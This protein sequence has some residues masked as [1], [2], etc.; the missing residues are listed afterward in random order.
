MAVQDYY[1]ALQNLSNSDKIFGYYSGSAIFDYKFDYLTQSAAPGV[2]DIRLNTGKLYTS[3]NANEVLATQV[4]ID[5]DDISNRESVIGYLTKL[6]DLSDKG[7]IKLEVSGSSSFN[8]LYDIDSIDTGSSTLSYMVVNVSNGSGNVESGD[9]NN[10]ISQSYAFTTSSRTTKKPIIVTFTGSE[11]RGYHEVD[12]TGNSTKYIVAT[13][14]SINDPTTSGS[15]P[16]PFNIDWG[17][18][19]DTFTDPN[20]YPSNFGY[21]WLWNDGYKVKHIK[22]NSRSA[23]GDIL[24]DFIKASEWVRFIMSNP[25]NSTGSLIHPASG[26]YA[27]DYQLLNVTKYSTQGYSHLF[28]DQDNI[29]TSFAVDV[30]SEENITDTFT[31]TGDYIVYASSSGTTVEPTRSISVDSSIPQ[32]YF[33]SSSTNYPTEQFF[34]GWAGANYYVNGSLTS[35]NG[36]LDDP[37]Q[38]FNSGSTERDKDGAANYIPSTLPF[39]IDATASYIEVPSSSFVEYASQTNLTQIGPKFETSTGDEIIYYYKEDTNQIIIRGSQYLNTPK[40][41]TPSFDPLYDV[42]LVGPNDSPTT[43]TTL[44]GFDIEVK[45]SQSLWLTRGLANIGTQDGNLWKYNRYLHRPFK[46]YILT[47]TG[48]TELGYGSSEYGIDE[49]G[50]GSVPVGPPPN[51]FESVFIAYSSSKASDRPEDGIYTFDQNL[52]EPLYIT[53]SVNLD[54][55][56]IDIIRSSSYGTASYG[57]NEFEYGGTGSGDDVLTWQTANL[58]LY[59]NNTVIATETTPINSSNIL[60]GLTSTLTTT[61]QPYQVSIGDTLKLSLEVENESSGFNSSLIVSSYTMSFNNLVYPADGLTPVTFNNYLELNDDCDPLINNI[62]GDRPNQRLQD[63]D[64]SV[65]ILNPINFDQIIKDEAVRATVPESNYTQIGF[66]HQRYGGSSTSRRQINE[67]NELDDI[68]STNRFYYPGDVSNINLVNKGKGP[69]LGKVPNIELKN[70][71]IAYFNKLIDPYPT[72]NGKTAYYVKYLIDETGTIFDPT[73][74]DINF[75]IFEKTFQLYDYDLKPTRTKVSLQD[76]E[77][78]KELS[79]LNDG[80]ASTFKLGEYPTP[81]L[82]T[83]TSSLGHTN[84]IILSG[85]PFFGTLGVGSDWTNYGINVNSL[86][87]Q[88]PLNSSLGGDVR[89]YSLDISTTDLYF[90]SGDVI[91]FENNE[92]IPTSS[93]SLGL[94]IDFPLDPLGNPANTSGGNLSDDFTINGSFEFTTTTC[95][96]KY[97][98]RDE[99]WTRYT[100]KQYFNDYISGITNYRQPF[101]LTL[102]PYR[103]GSK[104]NLNFEISSVEL[105]II[106]SPGASNEINYNPIEIERSPNGYNTQ[107]SLTNNEFKITPDSQYLEKRIIQDLLGLNWTDPQIRKEQAHL[108]GGGYTTVQGQTTGRIAGVNNI[109]VIYKWKINFKFKNIKQEDDFY[110]KVDGAWTFSGDSNVRYGKTDDFFHMHGTSTNFLD[111]NQ[112]GDISWRGTFTPD[113]AILNPAVSSYNTKPILKYIVTSPLSSNNQNA[114]GAPGPYWR[115]ITGTNDMLFMSSSILNQ[116]YGIFDEN[117]NNTNGNYYVQAKLDYIPGSSTDFPSTIEPSFTEFD[118][119]VDP[120]SL[121]IGDEIRFE[122]NENLVYTITSVDGRQAI[123]PPTNPESTNPENDGLRIIVSPPFED[124][125]G[126]LNEPSNFDFFVVRRYKE[127]KNFI[128]LDQQ[129]PYGFPVSASSS[130]GILLPEHRI[131]KYDRNPDEVLKD[132]IEKRI[133]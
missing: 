121:K 95:P 50:S 58:K 70:G 62:V 98:A 131:E 132:L 25:I 3:S 39:F 13:S 36:T 21:A 1:F 44:E 118:P 117:G 37:L 90:I 27:E 99:A 79:Q 93:F 5:E 65:D 126:N 81:I 10:P 22:I 52:I 112:E 11:L 61:L 49:Y 83:Q 110:F 76:I 124:S 14:G 104:S 133:I 57:D 89:K 69:S 56:S 109:A 80:L 31:A 119:V 43:Y 6:D 74:S 9:S 86:Q 26:L 113:V 8:L 16:A 38:S 120:W 125:E 100:N 64:Y 12:V 88:F 97:R 94:K 63:V 87:T 92:S 123:E 96:G 130:P 40:T 71:Y 114:N 72:L 17:V 42:Q 20:Y 75:S 47:S 7:Q 68:D 35:I 82:Y 73:L 4:Y 23:T 129:K 101:N 106:S 59:Q 60:Y 128:I 127:N 48:S 107:W 45:E 115:R 91:P 51:E 32:G 2:G 103:N 78:A 24:T 67:Y 29:D 105:H 84:N 30:S 19:E 55:T 18:P 108:I 46:T 54:Y 111:Q 66:S 102:E 77:E 28:V 41:S 34:R 116:T 122:N 53:A 85:S 33:P 15:L